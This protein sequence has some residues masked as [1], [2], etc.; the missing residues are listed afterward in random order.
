MPYLPSMTEHEIPMH[1]LFVSPK[2]VLKDKKQ[3]ENRNNEETEIRSFADFLS[4]EVSG[5]KRIYLVGEPGS[6]K[7]TFLHFLAL[8][9]SEHILP[10]SVHCRGECPHDDGF[11]D[12]E[13]LQQID[14]LFFVSLR[15]ANDYCRY[16]EIIRDQLLKNIYTQELEQEQAY[17]IV[18][19]VL[20]SPTTCI[21]SDG[22][23]ERSE[24]RRVG[25]ECV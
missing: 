7:S 6:G 17:C 15:D 1:E 25:K 2:I 4:T 8:M 9:W 5:C 16:E 21:A 22:L 12:S 3:A 20:E 11:Q 18:K 23:D 14:F 10:S 19:S 24:E 13:T